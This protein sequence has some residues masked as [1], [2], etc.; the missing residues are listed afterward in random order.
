VTTSESLRE[1]EARAHELYAEVKR[2]GLVVP[3]K[4]ESGLSREIMTLANE[5]FGVTKYWHKRIVRAGANTLLAYSANPDDLTLQADDILFFDFGPIF[6]DWEADLGETLVLGDDPTKHRL[7]RDVAT[8]WND[9]ADYFRRHP[10]ITCAE[11]YN[12]VAGLATK[13]GWEFG[14]YHAGHLVGRFPHEQTEG[15]ADDRYIRA[16][17]PTVM[18]SPGATGEPL[19]W[20]LEIHFIDRAR[21]IGG[22]QE[23]LLRE[24]GES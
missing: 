22:F 4:T 3:G 12:H 19:R 2:R 8:A 6:S 14:H 21:Q 15:D 23:A 10:G 9:G 16:D 5:M 11:L 1:A 13:L 20:I 24:P 7:A 18:R 17:N